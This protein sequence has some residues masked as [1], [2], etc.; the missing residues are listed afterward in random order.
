MRHSGGYFFAK[1]HCS[2]LLSD[3]PMSF[4]AYTLVTALSESVARAITYRLLLFGCGRIDNGIPVASALSLH[5]HSRRRVDRSASAPSLLRVALRGL[6]SPTFTA[7]GSVVN[8]QS[9]LALM[10]HHA[11]DRTSPSPIRMLCFDRIK[12]VNAIPHGRARWTLTDAVS[13]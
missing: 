11:P 12:A 9:R 13:W 7:L 3:R 5:S 2:V 4:E 6:S 10:S 1:V 8:S